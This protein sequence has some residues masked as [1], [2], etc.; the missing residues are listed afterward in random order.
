MDFTV[1]FNKEG[2]VGKDALLKQREAGPARRL[3]GFKLLGRGIPRQGYPLV[4]DDRQVGQV[5]S[6]S[7]SPT[8]GEPIG[9]GYVETQYAA[10]G[11]E[12][13][14]EVRG[15]RIP[16]RLVEGRFVVP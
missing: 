7:L 16:C 2:F 3:V 14:M 1:K 15:R 5:T 11:T 10:T 8:L 13:D 6:G 12:L 9:M 4:A